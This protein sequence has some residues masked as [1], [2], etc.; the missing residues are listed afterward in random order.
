[1]YKIEE[2]IGFIK[3]I[4]DSVKFSSDVFTRCRIRHEEADDTLAHF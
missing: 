4:V 2:N 3:Y 1:M